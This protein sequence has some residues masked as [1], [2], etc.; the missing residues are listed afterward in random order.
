LSLEAGRQHLGA[1]RGESRKRVK[2]ARPGPVW[3]T[4][5]MQVSPSPGLG[6]WLTLA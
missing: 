4:T 3:C 2:N 6:V 5:T 1:G